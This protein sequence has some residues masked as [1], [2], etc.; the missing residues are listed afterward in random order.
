VSDDQNPANEEAMVSGW[1]HTELVGNEEQA[2]R[3]GQL[4]RRLLG[5]MKAFYGVNERLAAGES[6]GFYETAVQLGDGTRIE[7]R[8][9][10]GQDALRI[11]V[12]PPAFVAPHIPFKIPAPNPTPV[13]ADEADPILDTAEAPDVAV[14]P[15][16]PTIHDP[17]EDYVP[18]DFTPPVD[19]PL[20]GT[21]ADPIHNTAT[22]PEESDA[23]LPGQVR[24]RRAAY[25]TW[26]FD[27]EKYT[28]PLF[29]HHLYGPMLDGED[30]AI[31]M[32]GWITGPYVG[33]NFTH[34]SRMQFY[35]R[36]TLE[37]SGAFGLAFPP[38]FTQRMQ[39]D[40]EQGRFFL[41][42]GQG[43]YATNAYT[44]YGVTH[45]D[46]QNAPAR[47]TFPSS[48]DPDESIHQRYVDVSTGTINGLLPTK[49]ESEFVSNLYG[50]DTATLGQG[51]TRGYG[52]GAGALATC[53]TPDGDLIVVETDTVNSRISG[54]RRIGLAAGKS[55]SYPLPPTTDV[56]LV[57]IACGEGGV[58]WMLQSVLGPTLSPIVVY[59]LNPNAE[60]PRWETVTVEGGFGTRD[61]S[62]MQSLATL[63]WTDYDGGLQYDPVT[64]AVLVLMADGSGAWIV[65]ALDCMNLPLPE[66]FYPFA[67]RPDPEAYP[68]TR[69]Q[70][71]YNGRLL[72]RY[73]AIPH[74]YGFEDD[75]VV[76]G[77]IA[78]GAMYDIG[79]LRQTRHDSY[80]EIDDKGGERPISQS[81][82]EAG[83]PSRNTDY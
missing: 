22:P 76:E 14:A 4:A 78:I 32:G 37:Q 17:V 15:Q 80:T 39:W 51:T 12:P 25:C 21:R 55:A 63:T 69:G 49:F 13:P 82:Y 45:W 70:Q 71:L 53:P 42:D 16:E 29:G 27:E 73:E 46:A 48:A 10:N 40:S 35:D 6:G 44:I 58:V 67:K 7:A 18:E 59:F 66:F 56:H 28:A 24:R 72:V 62:V 54:V 5:S 60:T 2:R 68:A 57:E 34:V 65:D 81:E 19:E 9:N 77:H 3:H 47:I 52:A 36:N 43:A 11:I 33:P 31:Y 79:F 30:G 83:D 8:T 75:T 23:L 20:P 1:L 64:G 61:M 38:L 50:I 74:N 41:L 26:D